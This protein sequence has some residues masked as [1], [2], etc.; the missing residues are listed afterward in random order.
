MTEAD[1]AEV[2]RACIAAAEKVGA[3]LRS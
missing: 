2:Q 3:Q 1:I